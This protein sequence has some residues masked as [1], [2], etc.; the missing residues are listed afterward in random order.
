[1]AKVRVDI[2]DYID[3][4]STQFLVHVLKSRLNNPQATKED[5]LLIE[6]ILNPKKDK[7]IRD[8]YYE[9]VFTKLKDKFSV[10]QL[11]QFLTA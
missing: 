6:H 11:E 4:V 5:K 7:S 1:M 3:E 9:E 10:A 8:E 2:E